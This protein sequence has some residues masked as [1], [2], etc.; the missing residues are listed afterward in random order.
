MLYIL[1]TGTLPETGKAIEHLK[2]FCQIIKDDKRLR[3]YLIKILSQDCTCK[4]AQDLV[5]SFI[6]ILVWYKNKST[7]NVLEH[8]HM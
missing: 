1:L 4:K 2:K 7:K 8:I 5:V 6:N 3:S